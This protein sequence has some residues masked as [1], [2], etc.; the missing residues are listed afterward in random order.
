MDLTTSIVPKKS[1]G[2]ISIG[3]QI[4]DVIARLSSDY[5]IEKKQKVQLSAAVSSLLIMTSQD[6][7]SSIQDWLN[8]LKSRIDPTDSAMADLLDTL[9]KYQTA[10]EFRN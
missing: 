3:E 4:A 5:T 2:G 6:S 8:P 1:L 9:N 10:L 7:Y